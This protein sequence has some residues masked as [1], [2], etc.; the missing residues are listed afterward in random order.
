[1]QFAE[2]TLGSYLKSLSRLYAN[3]SMTSG[4]CVL[5]QRLQDG[6][7]YLKLRNKL[8]SNLKSCVFA[9]SKCTKYKTVV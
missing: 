7:I 4:G 5:N 1:M 3:T 2:W 6:C 9:R 8:V